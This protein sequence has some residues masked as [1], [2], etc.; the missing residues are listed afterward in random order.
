MFNI[1]AADENE[2]RYMGDIGNIA[3]IAVFTLS[4]Y[5]II[6]SVRGINT[7]RNDLVIS[8]ERSVIATFAMVTVSFF[9]LFTL[10]ARS[11]FHYQYVTQ[12]S[13][14]DLPMFYKMA[15]LWAGQA[16][17]L[18]LWL[19]I[20]SGITA[21]AVIQYKNRNRE[22]MPYVM[23]VFGVTTLFFSFVCLFLTNPFRELVTGAAGGIIDFTAQ[24]GQG[25]NPLLQHPAMVIHPPILFAGYSGFLVPFAFAIAALITGQLDA[26]WIQSTRRWTIFSWL[27]LSVGILLGAK[28]AYVELGWGGYWAWDPVENAS[29]MPWLT[30]TAFLHSVIIQE[31][32]GMLKV[33]NMTLI[34]LTFI[35]CIFGTFITRSGIISSVHSFAQSSI[36]PAFSAFLFFLLVTSFSLLFYRFPLLKS[37]NRLDSLLSRE[38][39]FLFNNLILLGALFAT[40][41]GTIFPVISEW[42]TGTQVTVGA[43]YFNKVNVPIGLMLMLLTGVGPLFAW[44][45][46]STYSL[47]RNFLIPFAL[48]I[49]AGVIMYILGIRKIMPLVSFYLCFF[50]AITI[51]QEFMRGTRA[52][53]KNWSEPYHRALV[54][55]TMRNTRRYGGYIIHFGIVLLF[56]GFTGNSYVKDVSG[57]LLPGESL[58]IGDYEVLLDRINHGSVPLYDYSEVILTV[59]KDDS[60]VSRKL[61]QRR[62]YK[63]SQQPTTE[64]AIHSTLK[65]DLYLVFSGM[66][67]DDKA[68]MNVYLNP[69]VMWVWIG[70]FVLTIGTIIAM[71]PGPKPD[72]RVSLKKRSEDKEYAEAEAV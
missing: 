1:N 65:E 55:M 33:W 26:S 40:F 32:R 45:K 41:W 58:V 64:L 35:L 16:G 24:D 72:R 66:A 29:L 8:A 36:G 18:L 30:G 57:E 48:S 69:L 2:S 5:T 67:P 7:R 39:S 54:N 3:L 25:L 4:L 62:N 71:V 9:A 63:A 13:N 31:K 42:A 38:S 56:I 23:A 12:Y 17:S 70:G 14:R 44:R 20:L 19:F 11:D 59:K 15:G 68:V 53:H 37:E 21:F 27:L 22:L 10:L 52:R 47:K 51:V 50:V 61:A 46:T 49:I 43:P 6:T 60:I 34:L 28:W